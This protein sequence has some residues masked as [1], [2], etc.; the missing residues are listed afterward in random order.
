MWF[1]CRGGEKNWTKKE[2]KKLG[3]KRKEKWA[4]K[5]RKKWAENGFLAPSILGGAPP[6]PAKVPM[7][8]QVSN[9]GVIPSTFFTNILENLYSFVIVFNI[10]TRKIHSW[11]IFLK[12]C[13]NNFQH[14][15]KAHSC[16]IFLKTDKNYFQHTRKI[17]AARGG[18][19]PLLSIPVTSHSGVRGSKLHLIHP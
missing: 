7:S 5:K 9:L 11:Q 10:H 15:R 2:K 12:T 13:E 8:S 4:K 1:P 3:R 6:L 18:F 14:T 16:Q 17:L 19:S